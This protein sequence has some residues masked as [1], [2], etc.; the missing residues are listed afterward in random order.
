MWGVRQNLLQSVVTDDGAQHLMTI[1][2]FLPG[3]LQPSAINTGEVDLDVD[4]AADVAKFEIIG[5]PEPIGL[6]QI[7]KGEW[8]VTGCRSRYDGRWGPLG[9]DSEPLPRPPVFVEDFAHAPLPPPEKPII[10]PCRQGVAFYLAF[11]LTHQPPKSAPAS[12]FR[13]R[14]VD[15]HA[16]FASLMVVSQIKTGLLFQPLLA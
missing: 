6:L 16:I 8:F 14:T 7:G 2:E 4:V 1:D 9:F 10:A 11:R 5:A 15:V 12:K 13:V 3:G